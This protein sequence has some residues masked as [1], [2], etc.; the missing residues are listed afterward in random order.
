MPEI[1]MDQ[2]LLY[3]NVALVAATFVLVA[4]TAWYAWETRQIQK[5]MEHEREALTRPLLAFNVVAWQPLLLK[6]TVENVGT[7]VVRHEL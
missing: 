3:A 4:I 1:Q 5:R 6:L 2:A 7:G